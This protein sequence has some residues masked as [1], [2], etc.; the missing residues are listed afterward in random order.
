MEHL[1]SV[2]FPEAQLNALDELIAY[3]DGVKGGLPIFGH[4]DVDPDR[5]SDPNPP[6]PLDL[7]K[8]NRRHAG[9][10][11]APYE[12]YYWAIV[13]TPGI[14]EEG[15]LVAFCKTNTMEYQDIPN[16]RVVAVHVRDTNIPGKRNSYGMLKDFMAKNAVA[17]FYKLE[18]T[19][20]HAHSRG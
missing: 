17:E 13:L 9:G 6:F 14:A 16:A 10:T 2:P 19:S 4:K 18:A 11:V 5:K 7:Y 15:K 1:G 3:L 12:R 20:G 8:K